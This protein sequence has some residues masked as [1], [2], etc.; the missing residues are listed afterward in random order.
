MKKIVSIILVMITLFTASTA[1]A[2]AEKSPAFDESK[3]FEI[4]NFFESAKVIEATEERIVLQNTDI[5]A[6]NRSSFGSETE[7]VTT[8]ISFVARDEK[9]G[10]QML[11]E[12]IAMKSGSGNHYKEK[13]DAS[14][15]IKLYSRVYYSEKYVGNDTYVKLTK[16][17]GGI[18]APGS[19]SYVGSGITMTMNSCLVTQYGK[20]QEGGMVNFRKTNTYANSKRSWSYT[21]PSLGYIIDCDASQAGINYAVRL[22]RGNSWLTE[23]VNAIV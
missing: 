23:L 2:Y 22:K 3:A 19:G 14:G 1:F 13:W 12:A 5:I 6:E 18:N 10:H 21:L 17:T 9:E 15:Q 7:K 11:E 16:V 4:G 8:T 20:K